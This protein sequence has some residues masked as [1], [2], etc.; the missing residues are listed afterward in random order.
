MDGKGQTTPEQW[1]VHMCLSGDQERVSR[2]GRR[3]PQL[4][5]TMQA[6]HLSDPQSEGNCRKRLGSLFSLLSTKREDVVL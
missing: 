1:P 4:V 5:W 3:H 6:G 2:L